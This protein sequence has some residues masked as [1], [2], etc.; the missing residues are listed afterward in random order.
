MVCL[1]ASAKTQIDVPGK[2]RGLGVTAMV[3]S[4]ALIRMT[5]DEIMSEYPEVIPILLKSKVHC[6]G[7]M[8][9]S[10]HNPIDAAIVHGLDQREFL[11][12]LCSE[13][14]QKTDG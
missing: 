3:N 11:A 9:A 12:L 2:L 14:E 6:V 10:F 4:D 13:L 1:C 8:L 7:C 5:M